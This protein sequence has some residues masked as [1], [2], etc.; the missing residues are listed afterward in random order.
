M[1]RKRVAQ[2]YY[3]K[4]C[5]MRLLQELELQEEDLPDKSDSEE[6]NKRGCEGGV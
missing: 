3:L 4:V 1:Q 5:C 2:T 6:K